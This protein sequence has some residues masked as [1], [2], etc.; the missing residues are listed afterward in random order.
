MLKRISKI[1]NIGKFRNC[2]AAPSELGKLSIIYGL[3]TYGKSTL[4]DI[5]KSLKDNDNT[6]IKKRLSIPLDKA[7][8]EITLSFLIDGKETA[9]K[10]QGDAWSKNLEEG[11]KIHIFDE[12]FYHQNLF[13]SREFTR[14]T[15]EQFSAFVL[16]KKGVDKANAISEKNKKKGDLT[17]ERTKLVK[18]AFSGITDLKSFLALP[19]D[20]SMAE[21]EAERD[22]LR[23]M[24]A[25]KSKQY[26][27]LQAI[28]GRPTFKSVEPTT[29]FNTPASTLNEALKSTFTA[30][31][32]NARRELDEHI[33]KC[34]TTK[35]NAESWIRQ[36]LEQNNGQT[37]QFCGQ[38]L[39]EQAL[40]L[41]E[42][43]RKS[44]DTSFQNFKSQTLIT[45]QQNEQL[46]LQALPT[47]DTITI[48]TENSKL[49]L[50]YSDFSSPE[51]QESYE[52]LEQLGSDLTQLQ[53][54]IN[55]E[56]EV[57]KNTTTSLIQKKI[58]SPEHATN[59]IEAAT[60]SSLI[61]NY[62][63]AIEEYKN[64]GSEL[65]SVYR[66][67]KDELKSTDYAK[68]LAELTTLGERQNAVIKRLE[69]DNQCQEL[70]KSDGEIEQLEKEIPVL[71][72]ELQKE[73]SKYLDQFFTS[74]NQNF[75]KF[76][77]RDFEL[78]RGIN[79]QG[80]TPIYH[81]KVSFRNKEISESNIDRI[82][83]ESD[84]RALALAV[85]WTALSNQSN[86][87]LEKSIVILDD[88]VTSFD[89]NRRQAVHKEITD[90]LDKT[91]QIIILSHF[92]PAIVDILNK[93][94]RNIKI[95]FCEIVKDNDNSTIK[96]GDIDEFCRSEHESKRAKILA[97]IAGTAPLHD[98]SCL[99]VF[100]EYEIDSRFAKQIISNNLAALQL[101]DKIQKL[102]EHGV[103]G[104]DTRKTADS[105]RVEL[106]PEHHRWS[107]ANEEE[108]RQLAH[109]FFE[110]VYK[111]LRTA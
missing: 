6:A 30:E 49:A 107:D 104:E 48:I 33:E 10:Y 77:S 71:M 96:A 59:E 8:Q 103:I 85:Y 17:R 66:G 79:R 1:Q 62:N 39:S 19:T 72:A 25:K 74:L 88:P 54:L 80:N 92:E 32:K 29:D 18:D 12:D 84:R 102:H 55:D 101:S 15:K 91:R 9:I 31:D 63:S 7:A 53:E 14:A 75:Q 3:N 82:F 45:V 27:E 13:S 106:N 41:L 95:N 99:R 23:E 69:V 60:L 21:L 40:H 22:R 86:E 43:Y 97:F 105:W 42:Q 109:D 61:N 87:D 24:W 20:K 47:Q 35:E 110:F 64:S 51:L 98:S 78:T 50:I 34:F 70:I 44:F 67:I 52:K 76:G 28:L 100:L 81:L 58:Q 56:A 94:R 73:Q 46:A 111:D 4:T 89:M 36:G 2:N 37:C 38:G 108:R 5:F 83:S 93:H 57:F 65:N 11:L 16:G 90:I 26:K 68:E